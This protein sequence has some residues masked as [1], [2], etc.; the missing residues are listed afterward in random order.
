[1]YITGCTDGRKGK[2]EM[3]MDNCNHHDDHHHLLNPHF[4]PAERFR[5]GVE[6]YKI[7]ITE[8]AY[9]YIRISFAFRIPSAFDSAPLQHSLSYRMPSHVMIVAY[10][11]IHMYSTEHRGKGSVSL[12]LNRKMNS[13]NSYLCHCHCHC[14]IWA[15]TII[16]PSC[17]CLSQ[18]IPQYYRENFIKL[19]NLIHFKCVQIIKNILYSYASRE[20]CQW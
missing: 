3:N 9:T 5:W 7:L 17:N 6:A 15:L 11:G 4:A 8:Y 1:M 10:M 14:V 16:E 19:I 12:N 18:M 2:A 20:I 13:I